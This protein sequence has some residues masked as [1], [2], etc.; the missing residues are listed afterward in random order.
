[1]QR[2]TLFYARKDI[3]L[4]SASLNGIVVIYRRDKGSTDILFWGHRTFLRMWQPM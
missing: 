2:A 1:M 3:F 4:T